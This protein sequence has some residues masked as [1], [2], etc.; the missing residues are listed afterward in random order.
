M[1][2]EVVGKGFEPFYTTKGMLGTGLGLW[3]SK[4]I[5]DRHLG[6]LRIQSSQRCGRSGTVIQLFLPSSNGI[7]G[8]VRQCIQIDSTVPSS[9]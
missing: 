3:V 1:P 4:D 7:R 9:R 6:H 8:T 5:V 2:A